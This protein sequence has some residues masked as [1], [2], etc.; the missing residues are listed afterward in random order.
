[1]GLSAGTYN[2]TYSLK[3]TTNT[4]WND[5]TVEDVT[6]NWTINK[7]D[8][9]TVQLFT[10]VK[11]G[12]TK[13][14]DFSNAVEKDGILGAAS[15]TGDTELLETTVLEG[16]KLQ[17]RAATTADATKRV[18][19]TIPVLGTVTD[20]GKVTVN[21]VAVDVNTLIE[22]WTA[23]LEKVFPTKPRKMRCV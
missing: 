10:S 23:P 6:G 9:E 11:V 20:D 16:N 17:L 13:E 12:A 21:G 19:V 5:D 18:V 2:V 1:M 22:K 7:I 15:A 3:N 4:T 8:K 14:F